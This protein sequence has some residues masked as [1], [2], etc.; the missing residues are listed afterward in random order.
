MAGRFF[1][2]PFARRARASGRLGGERVAGIDTR[3]QPGAWTM[4][5]YPPRARPAIVDN[6]DGLK[7][8]C[9]QYPQLF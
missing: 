6:V 5:I 7:S 3:A 2:L 8:N 4:W 1:L 9:P